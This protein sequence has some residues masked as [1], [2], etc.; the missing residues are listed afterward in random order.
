[1]QVAAASYREIAP[2]GICRNGCHR[3]QT[4]MR[5]V[6]GCQ[7]RRFACRCFML[8]QLTVSFSEIPECER[9]LRCTKAFQRTAANRIGLDGLRTIYFQNFAKRR[10]TLEELSEP[11]SHACTVQGTTSCPGLSRSF[12]LWALSQTKVVSL[13]CSPSTLQDP[14]PQTS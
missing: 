2:T 12:P 8:G 4:S 6:Q 7:Q 11:I 13:C 1:M 9:S 3:N 10:G 5:S 14:C